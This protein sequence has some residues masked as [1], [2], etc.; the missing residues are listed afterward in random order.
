MASVSGSC[1]QAKAI[2]AMPGHVDENRWDLI[3]CMVLHPHRYRLLVA[4]A[5]GLSGAGCTLGTTINEDGSA[6]THHIGYVRHILPPFDSRNPNIRLQAIE[7]TGIVADHG[8]TIGYKRNGYLYL[9]LGN[10]AELPD[11]IGHEAC[12][13]VIVV[14]NKTQLDHAI[15]QL[16][17]LQGNLCVAVSP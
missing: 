7:T 3:A 11:E 5:L 9:P 15:E 2:W 12:N 13:L 1:S 17:H 8:L 10:D 4:L 16:Q 14:E 6:V